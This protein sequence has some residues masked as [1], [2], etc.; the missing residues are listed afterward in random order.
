MTLMILTVLVLLLHLVFLPTVF[1][2]ACLVLLDLLVGG[3][4]VLDLVEMYGVQNATL[5]PGTWPSIARQC[6][7]GRTTAPAPHK[8][9]R[10]I[11]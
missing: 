7:S 8:R 1:L 11:F 3:L 2:R 6:R 9:P 10:R 4:L 5:E